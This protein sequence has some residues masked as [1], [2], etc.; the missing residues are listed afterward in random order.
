MDRAPRFHQVSMLN[1]WPFCRPQRA[2]GP[3]QKDT[4]QEV[5][6]GQEEA[7]KKP[8]DAAA[9]PLSRRGANR[10][11]DPVEAEMQ[12]PWNRCGIKKVELPQHH[13]HVS[14]KKILNGPPSKNSGSSSRLN[15][16]AVTLSDW[17]G[18]PFT[19]QEIDAATARRQPSIDVAESDASCSSA[20][21]SV[22]R[23]RAKAQNQGRVGGLLTLTEENP[24]SGNTAP[25]DVGPRVGVAR[26]P[27][28]GK[29]LNS[30]QLLQLK[31][32]ALARAT[33]RCAG[34]LWQAALEG[35]ILKRPFA[36]A[37]SLHPMQQ[38][39]QQRQSLQEDDA[40]SSTTSSAMSGGDRLRRTIPFLELV[41]QL[42]DAL[43]CEISEGA[44]T[45]LLQ[46]G[47]CSEKTPV[48]YANFMRL[49]NS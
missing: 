37:P 23:R 21:S 29:V 40:M 6:H 46:M 43:D 28:S 9:L 26:A 5:L 25:C 30:S 42:E 47:N 11:S 13:E 35:N 1:E 34:E 48:R 17:S 44:L 14:G 36:S 39:Q 7:K 12:H 45:D 22:A 10:M 49:F 4:V 32:Q 24:F 20:S 2:V 38:L 27:P 31:A 16:P 15:T 3:A 18:R 33:G 8:N 41:V 19:Q